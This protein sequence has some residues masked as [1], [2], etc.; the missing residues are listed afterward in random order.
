MCCGKAGPQWVQ[1]RK[2]G[3]CREDS[4]NPGS[5]GMRIDRVRDLRFFT[6]IELNK[7][8]VAAGAV[9]VRGCSIDTAAGRGGLGRKNSISRPRSQLG[10]TRGHD[11]QA[12]LPQVAVS[13][14]FAFGSQISSAPPDS[15]KRTLGVYHHLALACLSGPVLVCARRKHDVP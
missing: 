13:L 8:L 3:V 6:W 12:R 15:L 2:F 1:G 7:I 10:A 5:G 4:S 11:V 14:V 9:G